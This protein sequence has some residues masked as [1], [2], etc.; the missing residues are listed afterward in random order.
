[1]SAGVRRNVFYRVQ[2]SF[3]PRKISRE[4]ARRFCFQRKPYTYYIGMR[5]E[6]DIIRNIII[7]VMAYYYN[8][9]YY[10]LLC[11]LFVLYSDISQKS[12]VQYVNNG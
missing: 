9:Y 1:M 3:W 4:S 10:L 6:V 8:F 2:H 7:I 12:V 11:C 5:H